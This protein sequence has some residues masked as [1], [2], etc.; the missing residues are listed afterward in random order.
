MKRSDT[1]ENTGELIIKIVQMSIIL[2]ILLLFLYRWKKKG[3]RGYSLLS[4][5]L[6][7]ALLQGCLETYF[8]FLTIYTN[9]DQNNNTLAKIEYIPYGL[10]FLFLILHFEYFTGW[11]YFS[12]IAICFIVSFLTAMMLDF[13]YNLSPVVI[14]PNTP[15]NYMN[16]KP[17]MLIFDLY[18]IYAVAFCFTASIY[19]YIKT[20]ASTVGKNT[21]AFI[22]SFFIALVVAFLEFLEHIFAFEIYGAIGFGISIIIILL[23]YLISTDFVYLTPVTVYRLIIIHSSADPIFS[24]RNKLVQHKQK[25]FVVGG[26]FSAFSSFISEISGSHGKSLT[27]IKLEDK[28]LL[29]KNHGSITGLLITDKI[30]KVFDYSL[31]SFLADFCKTYSVDIVNYVGDV[32]VFDQAL[33]LLQRSFP[34]L[35]KENLVVS[36]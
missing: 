33:C 14:N 34:Y 10:I 2:L 16:D 4:F 36:E 21:F 1:M 24:V 3:I 8:Y 31:R 22:I 5:A 27:N 28:Q 12:I 7:C 26:I 17:F 9:F 30:I 6:I 19:T 29:I 23:V 32:S 20:K 11:K 35:E 13:G 15:P 18:Q 25:D